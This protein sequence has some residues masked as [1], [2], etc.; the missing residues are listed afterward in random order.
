MSATYYWVAPPVTFRDWRYLVVATVAGLFAF[1]FSRRLVR[2]VPLIAVLD[3]A[4]LS[5]FAVTGAATAAA[6]GLGPGQAAIL[7][8]I[9]GA[10]VERSAI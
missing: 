7:G 8:V 10:R 3:A 9:T 2:V 1:A 5:L 4:G 6:L